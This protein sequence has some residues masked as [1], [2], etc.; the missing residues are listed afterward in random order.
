ME[1]MTWGNLVSISGAFSILASGFMLGKTRGEMPKS[2]LARLTFGSL[3][4]LVIGLIMIVSPY[5]RLTQ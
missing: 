3:A 1:L 4:L 5:V 2:K